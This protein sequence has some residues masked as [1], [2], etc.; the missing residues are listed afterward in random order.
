LNAV[1]LPIQ[2]L[3]TVDIMD[4]LFDDVKSE[5]FIVSMIEKGCSPDKAVEL[6]MKIIEAQQQK[7]TRDGN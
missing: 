2:I 4:Q 6:C 3:L 7:L 5:A 1:E